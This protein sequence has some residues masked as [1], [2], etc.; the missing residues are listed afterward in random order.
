MPRN[1]LTGVKPDA[2]LYRPAS[3]S[4]AKRNREWDRAQ[5]AAVET[6]QI[7]LR[8]VPRSL[9]ARLNVIADQLGIT[10]SLVAVQLMENALKAYDEN[11]PDVPDDGAE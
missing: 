11:V 7:S 10:V 1:P 5:R 8:G 2:L 6:C 9:N 3:V 4:R